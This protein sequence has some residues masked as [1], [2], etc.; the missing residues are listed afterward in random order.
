MS[1]VICYM[2]HVTCPLSHVTNAIGHPLHSPLSL[3]HR[4]TGISEQVHTAARLQW[5][6]FSLIEILQPGCIRTR[7]STQCHSDG[8][9]KVLGGE[10]VRC[11]QCSQCHNVRN[12]H[13]VHILHFVHIVHIVHIFH[14]IH[15]IHIV[16]IVH[17]GAVRGSRQGLFPPRRFLPLHQPPGD[18]FTWPLSPTNPFWS[19]ESAVGP[20]SRH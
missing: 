9:W 11:S 14:I 2:S 1:D 10:G 3:L 18:D 15:T 7:Q 13:I 19:G 6:N 16:H 8:V 17:H 5:L 12:V 4:R 20:G